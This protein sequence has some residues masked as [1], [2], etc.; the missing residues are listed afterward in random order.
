MKV[1]LLE[2]KHLSFLNLPSRV[3]GSFWITN[4]FKPSQ[5]LIS[6]EA[7]DGEWRLISNNDCYL[8][9]NDTPT[10]EA[11]L[12]SYNFYTY[13]FNNQDHLL[14][15]TESYDDTVGFYQLAQDADISIGSGQD[16]NIT[17][18]SS[19]MSKKYVHLS[20]REANWQLQIEP[21]AYVYLNNQRVN[22][23]I[24][25]LKSGD[26]LFIL[27][28]NMTIMGNLILINKPG[29]FS[30]INIPS[31]SNF[32]FSED[33]Y[34]YKEVPEVDYYKEEDYFFKTPR[35]RR[36]ISTYKLKISPP[37]G[38]QNKEDDTPAILL[39]GPMLTSSVTSLSS[40]FSAITKISSG[41][42]TVSDSWSTLLMSATMMASTFL[43]PNI[44][45]R[46]QK[47]KQKE[48]EKKRRSVYTEYLK[49]KEKS[50]EAELTTQSQILTENLIPL[51]ECYDIIK[52]KR[53]MLWERKISQKD[54]LTVRMGIG[55]VPLDAEV[56]LNEDEFVMEEDDM[57]ES[58]KSLAKHYQLIPSA[59]VG[60][61]FYNQKVTAVM[62]VENKLDTLINNIILQ[63]ITFHSYDDLKIV[64]FTT[65]NS[66]N[67]WSYIKKLPHAFSNDK[68][69]RFFSANED[70]ERAI[71]S[72]LE[73]ILLSRAQDS[74]NLE[75]VENEEKEKD[76]TFL[77]YYLILTDDYIGI[78]ELGITKMVME[79]KVNFGFGFLIKE[80]RLSRLPSEC[81]TFINVGTDTSTILST[82]LD[83]NY[84]QN[85]TN[86]MDDSINMDECA[87]VLS[88]IPIKFEFEYRNL[89]DSISF[90]DMYGAGKI[91]QLNTMNRW[92]LN[93]P[94]KSLRATIGVDDVGNQIYLDLHEKA[95]GPHG[96]IAGTTGSG[97][98]E[99][100]ITYILSMC[101]NYSPNEVAFILID[102]KGGGLAGAFE[103][104]KNNIRLPHLAGT[105]T[106]LDKNELNRT[107]ISIDS[108]LKRRQQKF[109]EARD[110]LG[111]S[112][113]DIYKYQRFF[114]EKKIKEPIPH[115]FIVCDEFAELK[116]QQPDF[117][118]D[119]ISA[120]RIGRSLGVHLIL[121]TQKPS[122]VVNDQIWS[123]TKFR[124]CLKVADTA[125][126]NEMIKC[127][128][129]AAITQAGR[130][131]LQVGNNEIFLMGQSGY[132][133][134]PYVPKNSSAKEIDRSL[135][136]IDNIGNVIK[137]IEVDSETKVKVEN[138]GDELSNALKYITAIAMRDKVS[139]RR[140]WLDNIPEHI[141][142]KDLVKKY[143]FINVKKDCVEGIIG[144]Y[145][146]PS[147]QSQ[148]IF[149]L[150]LNSEGNTIVY[151][152]SGVGREMLIKS[153]VYSC[154]VLYS[155]EDINFYIFDF[156]SES[157]RIFEKLPHVGDIVFANEA[158]KLNKLFRIIDGE[159]NKRKELLADY[160]GDYATYLRSSGKKLP[161]Y[162][163][164]INGYDSFQESYSAYE[165]LITRIARDG[166]RYGVLLIIATSSTSGMYSRLTRN[167]PNQIVL[168]MNDKNDYMNIL[169]KIGNVYPADYVGRGLFK[170]EIAYE[171]QVASICDD[172]Q[173]V[174][175][176][177]SLSVELSKRNTYVP[178]RVPVLP[179]QVTLD[180]VYQIEPTLKKIG[181][182]LVREDLST[183]CYNFK[184]D[185]ATII[186]ANDIE[187]CVPLIHNL[188]R[189]FKK[190]KNVLTVIIDDDDVFASEKDFVQGYFPN[191]QDKL[192]ETLNY[193]VDQKLP[194]LPYDFMMIVSGVEK[195]KTL[196][197]STEISKLMD[198]LNS[199]K[200]A[201]IIFVD[202]ALK[203]KKVAFD[204][205]YSSTV[206]NTSGIWVGSGA[207]E[208]SVIKLS[209]INKKYKE[210]LNNDFAWV[211]K[212]GE[213]ELVKLINENTDT[214]NT[215]ENEGVINEE[216]NIS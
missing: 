22:K 176:I 47:K 2:E 211:F 139:A 81:E 60:Y 214:V 4:P 15:I 52:N 8:K 133:G 188:A 166:S 65:Q 41:E 61:S 168:D 117:M 151:G 42:S 138:K 199:A 161:L 119:L 142:I 164:I 101:L 189:T 158:E 205:W 210:K 180:M 184:A 106:N 123:N 141:Y 157:L 198:K 26:S 55:D 170:K 64:V 152:L 31:L 162:V 25:D 32:A 3:E 99:F 192:L 95:H 49:E 105:I 149:T 30:K 177:K 75:V 59:P 53:R 73:Q 76:N 97:K 134:V 169:G 181:I 175:H 172:M 21:K 83:N 163:A 50:L 40:L 39:Y 183:Y 34:E 43:W 63:L 156:G 194:T 116:A 46:F 195:F 131:I 197:S 23:D 7:K 185:K 129:A 35:L 58:A 115:L 144:E 38:N 112:T 178:E 206:T 113:M 67:D 37:P 66:T 179:Q 86:E 78:R 91:E 69:I 19:I 196:G 93:D 212:N 132:A 159:I 18:T 147:N 136:F 89:P 186:S 118:D 54:F 190:M 84:Q 122:G 173:L 68:K 140:L 171:F 9:V 109:N 5:K 88:G 126:S 128:D 182:G 153:L 12:E 13:F 16:C 82:N 96:L 216:Q 102:Y 208:Q 204:S 127:P 135:A 114:R 120:A 200:N 202:S 150:K 70:E 36:F 191:T 209:D 6:I 160:N 174:D 107:L 167:F 29:N 98:S 203:L 56:D 44:T 207:M 111:E 90:L 14:Y 62:G 104:K 213:G 87:E 215:N 146:D 57:K 165:D 100:I 130:F 71:S 45:K 121:A 187:S 74:K 48:Q 79:S 80:S 72:Y 17:C 201:N 137:T 125:D 11:P 155:T 20:K 193:F 145:D 148:N 92:V 103:N 108:E 85:F 27:G 28:I 143:D 154:S 51:Q 77:P 124:V 33:P 10:T 94:T 110:E 1:I 24:V